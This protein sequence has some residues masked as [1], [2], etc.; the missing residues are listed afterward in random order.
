VRVGVAVGPGQGLRR[1]RL[2]FERIGERRE[3]VVDLVA[4]AGGVAVDCTTAPLLDY[5]INDFVHIK[6]A[7][8]IG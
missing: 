7:H 3:I 2:V 4:D 6:L 1:A 8:L 5:N